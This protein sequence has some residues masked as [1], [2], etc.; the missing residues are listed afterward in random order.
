MKITHKNLDVEEI[1]P[2]F[3]SQEERCINKYTGGYR[4]LLVID[5]RIISVKFLITIKENLKWCHV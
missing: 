1:L 3:P 2:Y 4:Y 5:Q